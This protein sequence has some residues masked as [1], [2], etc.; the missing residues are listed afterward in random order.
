MVLDVRIRPSRIYLAALSV[1]YAGALVLLCLL[2]MSLLARTGALGA[3][4][5][6]LWSVSRNWESLVTVSQL[7][8]EQGRLRLLVAGR[9]Y[10][11]EI[12]KSVLVHPWLVV[13]PV[14]N[15]YFQ[16]TLLL[17]P[18]TAHADDLRRLRVWLKGFV[19]PG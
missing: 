8:L 19:S 5:L 2:P 14:K 1:I 12:G 11:V 17:F 16:K 15:A 7:K 10:A 6:C 4:L 3:Y 13:L 18:D 9:P